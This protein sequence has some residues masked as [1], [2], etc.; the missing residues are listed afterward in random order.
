MKRATMNIKAGVLSTASAKYKIR[1]S[2]TG[3]DWV[4]YDGEDIVVAT[5]NW[6][7]EKERT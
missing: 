2:L 3:A 7:A 6:T 4:N 1:V 5:Y